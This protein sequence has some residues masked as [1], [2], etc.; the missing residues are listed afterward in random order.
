MAGLDRARF[1]QPKPRPESASHPQRHDRVGCPDQ[2]KGVI[3]HVQTTLTLQHSTTRGSLITLSTDSYQTYQLRP[4]PGKPTLPPS[5]SPK[6]RARIIIS[7]HHSRNRRCGLMGGRFR[8]K[9]GAMRWTAGTTKR[10][11]EAGDTSDP[12]MWRSSMGHG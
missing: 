8:G 6:K 12:P 7:Q 2:K 5:L 1:S 9:T 10:E 3:L 11:S 4:G